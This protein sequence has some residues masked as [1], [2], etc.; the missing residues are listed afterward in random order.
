MPHYKLLYPSKYVAACDLKGDTP[1]IIRSITVEAV[2]SQ[3]GTEDKVIV[4]F[5]KARKAMILNKTNA[6]AIAKRYGNDTDN[7]IGKEAVLYPTTCQAFGSE[8]ECIRVR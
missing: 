1:M 8:H 7:W 4:R 5:E 2:K 3:E 6:T